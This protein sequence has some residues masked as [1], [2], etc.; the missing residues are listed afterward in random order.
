MCRLFLEPM[1]NQEEPA[2]LNVRLGN[3]MLCRGDQL[4]HGENCGETYISLEPRISNF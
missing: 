1:Y 4:L 3:L 2:D